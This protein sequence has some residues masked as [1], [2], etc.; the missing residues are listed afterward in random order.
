[1]LDTE[2]VI[3]EILQIKA[4]WVAEVGDKPRRLWPKAIKERVL[5]LVDSGIRLRQIADRTGVPYE[6][7]C[8]WKFQREHKQR[9]FHQVPVVQ[10]SKEAITN[11][12]TVAAPADESAQPE[13]PIGIRTPDGYV[14]KVWSERSAALVI[15]SLRQGGC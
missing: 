3:S 1:M 13:G 9:G 11:A 5:A 12:G 4:Q 7:V 8:Q 15:T 6:T 2:S 10:S 14:I